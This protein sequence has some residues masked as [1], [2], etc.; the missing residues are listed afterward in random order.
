MAGPKMAFA[1][2]R[3]DTQALPLIAGHTHTIGRKPECDLCL[4]SRSVSGQHAVI[5]VDAD[6]RQAVLR[7]LASLN[8]CFINNNRLKGQREVLN[9]GDNVR[10]GFDTRIWVVEQ[11]AAVKPRSP[12]QSAAG[13]WDHGP[14]GAS[15]IE[16]KK[17]SKPPPPQL[18]SGAAPLPGFFV[19]DQP[20]AGG[21]GDAPTL[22]E[23]GPAFDPRNAAPFPPSEE[24]RTSE[25]NALSEALL[26]GFGSD[27]GAPA[28][29]LEQ[30]GSRQSSN[31]QTPPP[32]EPTPLEAPAGAEGLMAEL[33][34]MMNPMAQPPA[35]LDPPEEENIDPNKSG[36]REL[37][38][39]EE[40]WREEMA[41]LQEKL[42]A[43]EAEQNAEREAE[44]Q[45]FEQADQEWRNE[46]A[47]LQRQL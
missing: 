1:Y 30:P 28:T 18:S 19:S 21:P 13:S 31:H 35:A 43:L 23:Q 15:M 3:S 37:G 41:M 39:G 4:K 20:E 11:A 25:S 2:L 40:E 24:L 32:F 6:G 46:A 33:E 12:R 5:E 17:K 36:T 16:P 27:N 14:N 10:F 7:D 45:K 29:A 22:L 38:T 26:G 47:E 44:R 8:G 42:K 9:H 34:N